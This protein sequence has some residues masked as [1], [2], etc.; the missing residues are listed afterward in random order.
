M[1]SSTR[2]QQKILTAVANC[3]DVAVHTTAGTF[4]GRA[5]YFDAICIE[6]YCEGEGAIFI[7]APHIV[8][9]FFFD[10][11]PPLFED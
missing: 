10:D 9:I 5:E 2:L 6:L 11:E 3:L 8:A 7:H 1:Y 4:T